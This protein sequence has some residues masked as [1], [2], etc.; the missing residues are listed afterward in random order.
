MQNVLAESVDIQALVTLEDIRN[1]TS[2]VV[3]ATQS[4]LPDTFGA[5]GG[6]AAAIGRTQAVDA[7]YVNPGTVVFTCTDTGEV[8]NV[9]DYVAQP[10]VYTS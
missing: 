6:P 4:A 1:A 9:N 3:I 7:S 8:G 5:P 10:S 2:D